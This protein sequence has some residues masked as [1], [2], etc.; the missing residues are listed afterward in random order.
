MNA[1]DAELICLDDSPSSEGSVARGAARKRPRCAERERERARGSGRSGRT[2]DGAWA[3][4]VVHADARLRLLDQEPIAA[5]GETKGTGSR[6]TP[7]RCQGR[8]ERRRRRRRCGHDRLAEHRS[9]RR[10]QEGQCR[11]RRQT[12]RGRLSGKATPRRRRHRAEASKLFKAGAAFA[13]AARLGRGRGGQLGAARG[14][15]Q[16]LRVRGRQ[17]PREEGLGERSGK[18][19]SSFCVGFGSSEESRAPTGRH[20]S[21]VLAERPVKELEAGFQNPAHV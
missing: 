2:S 5:A 1:V 12:S 11:T 14:L 17:G 6:C 7:W 13:G 16:H 4:P 8:G 19:R 9:R 21:R 20:C 15:F 3:Q 10:R 18:P